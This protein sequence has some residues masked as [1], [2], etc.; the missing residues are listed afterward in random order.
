MA[1]TVAGSASAAHVRRLSLAVHSV[2]LILGF[3][4]EENIGV[5]THVLGGVGGEEVSSLV[6]ELTLG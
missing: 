3:M 5:S 1:H 4:S 6:R 2:S